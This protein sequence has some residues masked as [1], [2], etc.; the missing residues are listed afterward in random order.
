VVPLPPWLYELV[1]APVAVGFALHHARR[2][3]GL[4]RALGEMVSLAAYGYALERAAIAVFR[5]HDYGQGWTW[6]P[7]GVP[8]AVAAVWAAVLIAAMAVAGRRGL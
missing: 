8:L 4:A 1:V 7:G 6:A 5:S 2:A 3:L